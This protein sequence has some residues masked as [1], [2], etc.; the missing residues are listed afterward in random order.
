MGSLRDGLVTLV[1]THPPPE[2]LDPAVVR[3]RMD[4]GIRFFRPD[5]H[6]VWPTLCYSADEQSQAWR[7][8]EGGTF[9]LAPAIAARA[10]IAGGRAS[11]MDG[12]VH[13]A[14]EAHLVDFLEACVRAYADE[15]TPPKYREY[16]PMLDDLLELELR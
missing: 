3:A 5:G 15:E 9:A 8:A 12:W 16:L 13:Y 2:G 7:P 14:V 6:R 4:Q 11:R 10:A 1:F